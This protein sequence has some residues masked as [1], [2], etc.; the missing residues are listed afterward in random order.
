MRGNRRQ[1]QCLQWILA[2]KKLKN[3]VK[4]A[5]LEKSPNFCFWH[6]RALLKNLISFEFDWF[7]ILDI[8][9]TFP[10]SPKISQNF[11][12]Q[13]LLST[14]PRKRREFSTTKPQNLGFLQ[15]IPLKQVLKPFLTTIYNTETSTSCQTPAKKISTFCRNRGR[16]WS[17]CLRDLDIFWVFLIQE[18]SLFS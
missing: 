8:S 3:S 18:T 12:Q 7:L 14:L 17:Q 4:R 10:K 9:G 2:L 11:P 16:W 5:I 6:W 1:H 15:K 13:M